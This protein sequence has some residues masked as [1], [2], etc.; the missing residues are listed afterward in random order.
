MPRHWYDLRVFTRDG[1]GGN[2]LAVVPDAV[3]VPTESLQRGAAEIGYSETVYLDWV[4]DSPVP[5]LRIFTPAIEIPF[6]GHPLVGTAWLLEHLG[7]MK[8][9]GEIEPPVGRLRCGAD[10]EGAWIEVPVAPVQ[11]PPR[12]ADALAAVGLEEAAAPVAAG[13]GQF[14][15]LVEAPSAAVVGGLRPDLHAL[16]HTEGGSG[17]C[18][19]AMD[20][21]GVKM[22][23]FAPASGVPEDPA[24][25]SAG[26]ALASVLLHDGRLE[27]GRT[28][29]IHQGDEVG[30]P[31]RILVTPCDGHLR[32]AGAVAL[33][34]VRQIS[35]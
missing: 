4:E 11:E 6:A 7:P 27:D 17:L 15:Y 5:K 21:E 2:P 9:M 18:V 31:S 35:L 26:A 3:E 1:E 8:G 16:E 34:G 14:W 23:F 32:L 30:R 28:L 12:L 19:W 25:G 29:R 24:T 13:V 22:R 20:G 33:D 10:R